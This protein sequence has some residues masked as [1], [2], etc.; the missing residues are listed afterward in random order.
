M[1]TAQDAGQGGIEIEH[2]GRQ[3]P[4]GEVAEGTQDGC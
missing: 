4:E 3:L 2:Q 1:G